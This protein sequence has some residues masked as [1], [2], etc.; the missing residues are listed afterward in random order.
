[1]R[2]HVFLVSPGS[3]PHREIFPWC[4]NRITILAMLGG[5]FTT[6][7]FVQRVFGVDPH[8][9]VN[10]R[11]RR[12]SMNTVSCQSELLKSLHIR[13]VSTGEAVEQTKGPLQQ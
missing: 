11:D 5:R 6:F 10:H 7:P 12:T 8:V 3:V 1:M 2:F 4:C 9:A 13:L